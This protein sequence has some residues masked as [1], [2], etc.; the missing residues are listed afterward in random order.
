MLQLALNLDNP[1]YTVNNS[2][3][4]KLILKNVGEDAVVVNSRLAIN[5]AFAPALFREVSLV[6]TDPSGAT[7]EFASK[8]NIGEPK[9]NDFK[10]LAPGELAERAF[11]IDLYYVLE[12]PGDYSVQAVYNNQADPGDGRMAWKGELKS[13]VATFTLHN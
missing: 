5:K 13:N 11:D 10:E 12:Q 2:I 7:A 4:G 1:T 9:K 3:S 8:V 6:V